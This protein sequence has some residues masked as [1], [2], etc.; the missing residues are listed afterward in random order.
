MQS[1][2]KI[3]NPKHRAGDITLLL[4]SWKN[5]D[6]LMRRLLSHFYELAHGLRIRER[7]WCS[8]TD[9]DLVNEAFIKLARHNTDF[10]SRNHFFG[11]VVRAMRQVLIERIRRR[12]TLKRGRNF[13]RVDFSVA[14]RVGF[15][16]RNELLHFDAALS[17]LSHEHPRLGDIVRMH[18]YEGYSVRETAA[19]LDC[20][21][22]T[23][24]RDLKKAYGRLSGELRAA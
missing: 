8:L 4:P 22:S 1:Q 21:E 9:D 20:S 10:K 19:V 16:D 17:R 6:A 15:L 24:R 11:A 5:N 23:V 14:E 12:N 2:K 18:V 13:S 7:S 3:S